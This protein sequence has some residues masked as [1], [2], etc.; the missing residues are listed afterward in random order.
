MALEA[1]FLHQSYDRVVDDTADVHLVNAAEQLRNEADVPAP[2]QMPNAAPIGAIILVHGT[3][4]GT[5]ALGLI[6]KLARFW[7]DGAKKLRQQRKEWFD[8]L[9]QDGGNYTDNYAQRL[10]KLSGA[11]T[12]NRFHWSSENH[13]VGRAAGAIQL[14]SELVKL[15]RELPANSRIQIWAHSHGGNV[16]ALATQLLGGDEGRRDLFFE[17][18]RPFYRWPLIRKIDFPIWPEVQRQLSNARALAERLD[19]V[20]F[21]TPIRYGWEPAGFKRLLHFVHHKPIHEDPYR[22]ALPQS[23]DDL[24]QC[25]G[26][27]YVQHLGIAGTNV[28]PDLFAWR[29]RWADGRLNR[30]LQVGIRKRDLW[31][32][33]CQGARAHD[34]GTSLL[35][36]YG[37]PAGKVVE[38]VFGHAVY[39]REQW[40]EFHLREIM[41]R[42]YGI[43]GVTGDRD[44]G[45][46]N[47]R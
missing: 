4:A 27:D 18:A 20:T 37:P 44:T 22:A 1:R 24:L 2:R 30:I 33:M 41:Q 26:G 34:R 29:A 17:A 3:F 16:L 38:D 43:N 28:A 42:F 19:L 11:A 9:V 13:H 10:G 5:D 35:V 23:V 40:L 25:R 6:R 46:T 36:D 32:R 47:G 45:R 31:K 8:W 15:D 14:L 21:G 39:T 12:V 7:P